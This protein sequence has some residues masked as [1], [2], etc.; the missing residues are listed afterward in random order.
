VIVFLCA[1]VLAVAETVARRAARDPARWGAPG[2][3]LSLVSALGVL[4]TTIAAAATGRTVLVGLVPVALGIGLRFAAIRAL[5]DAFTSETVFVPGRPI[6]NDGVF[7]WTRHPS[8]LGLVLYASG[9]AILG[10]STPALGFVA[11]LVVP[12]TVLRIVTEERDRSR[13]GGG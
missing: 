12:S 4:A 13:S 5:G 11:L 7:A 3:V 1:A 6:V 2:T 9:I 8:D 10:E